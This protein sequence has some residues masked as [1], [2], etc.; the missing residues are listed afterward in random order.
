MRKGNIAIVFALL[1]VILL[2]VG[3]LVVDLG[4][5]QVVAVELQNGAD[6]GAL[7][8]ASRVGAGAESAR[9]TAIALA[10][11]NYA[12][13]AAIEV[14]AADVIIGTWDAASRTFTPLDDED[15]PGNA[16]RVV[17]RVPT[18]VM[19][20]A[21]ALGFANAPIS[22][23]AIAATGGA[24]GA[25]CG[26]FSDIKMSISGDTVIDAYDST[27]GPYSATNSG[28][29]GGVCSNDDIEI[30][31]DTLIEGDASCGPDH[32]VNISSGTVTGSTE[33][34]PEPVLVEAADFGTV[35]TSNSNSTIPKTQQNQTALSSSRDLSVSSGDTLTLQA[36]DYYLKTLNVSGTLRT[37]GDVRLFVQEQVSISGPGIVNT[38]TDPTRLTILTNSTSGVNLSGSAAFYGSVYAPFADISISGYAAYYGVF[39]GGKVTLSGNVVIHLDAALLE[40][41]GS[42]EGSGVLALVR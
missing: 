31:G 12:G 3:A 35:A 30:S 16:V 22:R 9:S 29:P 39:F 20:F 24:G 28:L 33:C 1:L 18:P 4:Y 38:G 2:S 21:G 17:T 36:G 5:R 41:S 37:V 40:G 25:T 8:G 13:G 7:A 34:L 6:A 27:A 15:D 42:S 14:P 26:V 23:E 11:A 10:G 32:D 19:F